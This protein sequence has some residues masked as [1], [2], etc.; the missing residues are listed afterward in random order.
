MK[1]RLFSIVY[2]RQLPL[3]G[4]TVHS[5]ADMCPCSDARSG[6]SRNRCTSGTSTDCMRVG[7]GTIRYQSN[8]VLLVGLLPRGRHLRKTAE[9]S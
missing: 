1:F 2:L 6:S 5:H 9:N 7:T 3:D 4:D 8:H